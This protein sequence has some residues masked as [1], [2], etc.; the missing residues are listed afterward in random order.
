ME[1]LSESIANLEALFEDFNK[2]LEHKLPPLN[3][4]DPEALRALLEKIYLKEGRASRGQGGFKFK[5]SSQLRSAIADVLLLHEG[6]D[7]QD[8][9]VEPPSV[10]ENENA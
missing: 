8:K 10:E 4:E 1:R 7:Y 2:H 6:K 5:K 9:V 3:A